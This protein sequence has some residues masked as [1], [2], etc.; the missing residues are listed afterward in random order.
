VA[1]VLTST[2]STRPDRRGLVV[3]GVLIV[4]LVVGVVLLLD[5]RPIGPLAADPSGQVTVLADEPSTLDPAAQ[6]DASSAVVTAQLFESLT[7]FDAA[8][9]LRPALAEA[10]SIEDDGRRVVF[11]IRPGLT[12]SDGTPL[13]ALDVVRSWLRVIDPEAPSPLATLM[14]AVSGAAD[15]LAGRAGEADVGLSA[16][17][18]LV[19]AELERPGADFPA[20]V[21]SPTFAVVPP[22]I[23]EDPGALEP[24]SFVASGGYTLE[25]MDSSSLTLAANEHYWAGPPSIGRVRLTTDIAGASP[26]DAFASGDLDYAGIGQPDASWIRYDAALG[27]S[28]RE[29]PSL[30]LEYLGFDTTEPPFDDARVRRAIG[31]AVDWRRVV[32]LATPDD[33]LAATGMVPPGI[34]GRSEADFLPDHDPDEARRLMAAAGYPD[35]RG[36]PDVTFMSGGTAYAEGILADLDRELGIRPD[37]R[38]LE[39]GSFFERLESDAPHLWTLGWIADYPGRNDFLGVLLE[40]GA[41]NNYGGWSSPEFDAAILEAN[42]TTESDEASVAYD[43]AEEIVRDEVPA[44]PLAYGTGWALSRHELLGAGTNGL[45]ILRLAGMAWSE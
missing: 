36:F 12:F 32:S 15:R 22:G 14:L 28:L 19:I 45:G 37:Y 9:T 4:V 29:V 5:N 40:S 24:G 44:V 10:W 39:F 38:T 13:T 11:R 30:S 41:S 8:L 17:G 6:G 43:R 35:G 21:S 26:V 2:T 25:A 20:I 1:R 42:S 33:A 34:P 31:L 3:V 16:E 27:P 18:A 7:T 23:D